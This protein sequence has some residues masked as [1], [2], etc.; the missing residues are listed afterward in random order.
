MKSAMDRGS[1][2]I[3]GNRCALLTAGPCGKFWTTCIL[4]TMESN[5]KNQWGSYRA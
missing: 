1:N 4:K 3:H 2:R 5:M